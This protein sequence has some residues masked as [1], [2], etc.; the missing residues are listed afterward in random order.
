M[1]YKLIVNLFFIFWQSLN[2]IRMKNPFLI[3]VLFYLCCTPKVQLESPQTTEGKSKNYL[4]KSSDYIF[5]QG[6][7]HTFHLNLTDS[8]MA[9]LDVDPAA[10]EYVEGSLTF[11]GETLSK[12]GIRYKGSVGAF[13]YCLSG[14]DDPTDN[15]MK[16]SGHKVCTKL[17]M[18]IK[19]DWLN[20]Y[21]RFYGLK[22]LQFHSQN[23]DDSKMRERMGYYLFREMGIPAPRSVHARLMINGKY[24]SI[25]SLTEQI[26]EEF[27]E[28]HFSDATGNLYKETWPNDANGNA[29]DESDLIKALK[30]NETNPSVLQLKKFGEEISAASDANLNS[31]IEKW[32]N[33]QQ[34]LSYIVVDRTIRVDDGAFHWYCFQDQC[35]NHNLFWYED[36]STQKVHLIP[37]DMDN[38]FENII[39]EA[40]PVTPVADRWGDITANCE[41]FAYGDMGIK[42]R[43]AVCDKLTRG[44]TSYKKEYQDLKQKLITGAMTKENTDQLLNKWSDQIRT[45]TIEATEMFDDATPV[46]KWDDAVNTLRAQ[47]EYARAH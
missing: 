3:V 14:T 20:D 38:T 17:S 44:W 29:R 9:K 8:L 39:S 18:K 16:P 12:V 15:F 19:V 2:S 30:T 10:E 25:Y 36:P 46:E 45:A 41:P 33:I 22:K 11:E 24:N 4:T 13:V 47:L 32:M 6:K 5:D 28:E 37:W 26:D 43:S 34:M 7:L 27:I 40:N 21:N 23:L 1:H 31:V 35:S 42:Q